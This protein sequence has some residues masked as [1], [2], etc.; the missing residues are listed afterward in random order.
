MVGTGSSTTRA[1]LQLPCAV[2]QALIVAGLGAGEREREDRAANDSTSSVGDLNR[3]GSE[4]A[5]IQ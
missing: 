2:Q 4:R 1:V 5:K 3:D